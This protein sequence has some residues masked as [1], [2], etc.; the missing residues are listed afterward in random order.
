M[1]AKEIISILD[2]FA[3]PMLIDSWDNTGFQI[4]DDNKDI[5]KVIIS[6]DLDDYTLNK[7]IDESY[8]MIITHHPLIFKPITNINNKS[9]SSKRIMKLISNE[10]VVYNA[11]SNLDL[12]NGG[13]NDSLAEILGIKDTKALNEIIIDNSI[14]GYGRIGTVDNI[15]LLQ[16]I[17]KIKESLSVEDIRVFGQAK[18]NIEKVAVCGGSG[19]DFILDAYK[20]GAQVYLTGD[21]KYHQAQEAIDLGLILIDAGHFHTEKIIL[22]KLK[23]ILLEKINN[24]D[25]EVNMLSSVKYRIY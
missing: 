13:V 8:D 2:G 25:I 11:H 17:E 6:L 20:M 14:Y 23:K 19:G 22:P 16:F 24:I 4:G 10:I 21:I 5:K 12:A 15:S 18:D 3:N 9:N 7:A 1:K